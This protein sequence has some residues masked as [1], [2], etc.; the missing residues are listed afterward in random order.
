GG[1]DLEVRVYAGGL[2]GA[3]LEALAHRG[4][5]DRRDDLTRLTDRALD[6]FRAPPADPPRTP[7]TTGP[8]GGDR[9]ILTG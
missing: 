5:R 8:T 3:L 2:V 9:D 7:R 6:I 1:S 4:E